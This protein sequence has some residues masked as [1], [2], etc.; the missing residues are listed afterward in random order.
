MGYD[1]P[2]GGMS[3]RLKTEL[4]NHKLEIIQLLGQPE[5]TARDLWTA[6]LEEIAA[7]WNAHAAQRRD[8]RHAAARQ[9]GLQTLQVDVRPGALREAVLF[10]C[11]ANGQHGLRRSNADKRKS[12]LTLLQDPEWSQWSDRQIAEHVGVSNRFVSTLRGEL[13]VN[14]SQMRK[15][16]RGGS[17]FLM[18]VTRIGDSQKIVERA[19]ELLRETDIADDRRQVARLTG[20]AEEV[21]IDVAERIASGAARHVDQ[22]LKQINYEGKLEV[23][24]REIAGWHYPVIYGDPPWHFDSGDGLRG[25]ADN[26]YPTMSTEEICALPVKE[27]AAE[28]AVLFLWSTNAHLPDA[29]RVMSEWGFGYRTNFAWVKNTVGVGFYAMGK[30]ELLLLGI[31]GSLLP[32]QVLPSVFEAKT[33]GHSVKPEE[34]YDLIESMYPDMPKYLELFARRPP[35]RPRWVAWGN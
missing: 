14:G 3:P 31:R 5:K 13:S 18:N 4:A 22:A 34:A 1:A 35:S 32:K 25:V 9:A 27:K 17:Q 12:A 2:P 23:S 10:S 21:Q 19:R 24:L 11:A 20:R 6:T 26:H 33:R 16:S 28:H 7:A 30:H 8:H 29:L 15:V